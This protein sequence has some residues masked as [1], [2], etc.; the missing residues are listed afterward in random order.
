[1]ADRDP[2]RV[3]ADV[4]LREVA[5]LVLA[6]RELD[7]LEE[8]EIRDVAAYFASLSPQGTPSS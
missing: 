8:Q 5:R 2:G 6:S 3:S 4:N 7:R 1:M